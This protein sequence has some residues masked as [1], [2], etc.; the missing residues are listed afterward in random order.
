MAERVCI[1]AEK[2]MPSSRTHQRH[3]GTARAQSPEETAPPLHSPAISHSLQREHTVTNRRHLYPHLRRAEVL[4][5]VTR[6]PREHQARV[7][8]LVIHREESAASSLLCGEGV[9]GEEITVIAKGLSLQLRR[10]DRR[11]ER[12]PIGE[13]IPPRSEPRP[14]IA[15]R[16]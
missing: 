9:P 14:A 10:L 8:V 1:C 11:G 15:G 2:L 4:P 7:A 13:V 3:P 6:E 12:A 5:S 16:E